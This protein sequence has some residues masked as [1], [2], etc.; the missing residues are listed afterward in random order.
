MTLAEISFRNGRFHLR[1]E[2]YGLDESRNLHKDDGKR[3]EGW[4]KAYRMPSKTGRTGKLFS[5]SGKRST[6][7]ST[8]A[9]SGSKGCFAHRP[10]I[11]PWFLNFRFGQDR[12]SSSAPFSKFPG[13]FRPTGPFFLPRFPIYSTLRSGESEKRAKLKTLPNTV[14]PWFLWP[15]ILEA[16]RLFSTSLKNPPFWKQPAQSGWI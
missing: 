12:T 13:K 1:S 9:K 8:G 7:G 6:S 11:R 5:I 15:P 2:S 10:A 14:F 4:I 16:I 3:F